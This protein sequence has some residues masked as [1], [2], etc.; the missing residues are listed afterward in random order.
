MAEG[1]RLHPGSEGY[2]RQMVRVFVRRTISQALAD[3]AGVAA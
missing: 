1:E 3:G 2:R